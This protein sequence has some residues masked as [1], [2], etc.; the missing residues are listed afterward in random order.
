MPRSPPAAVALHLAAAY[1][2]YWGY[3]TMDVGQMGDWVRTQK[4][5]HFQFLTI[6]G[7]GVA[8]LTMVVSLMADILP[9][10]AAFIQVKR[11]L[12]LISM[13]LEATISS[14]YWPL[15]ILFPHLLLPTSESSAAAA[16][17]TLP[18]KVDLAL[19]AVPGIALT[20]DFF[21]FEKR[22]T[23]YQVTHVAPL[24]S[25]LFGLWYVIWVE[26]CASHNGRFPYPFLE[27]PYYIR[28]LVY[29]GAV[30]QAIFSFRILNFLHP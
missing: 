8:W 9:S 25:I 29:I 4:G 30:F 16:L 18:L 21:L 17:I 23:R 5:Q 15:I 6:Q 14:I 2:M 20:L 10:K 28:A 1:A 24:S 7:L 12:L 26:Y 19:H 27:S 3:T 13:P 11:G 22:Y